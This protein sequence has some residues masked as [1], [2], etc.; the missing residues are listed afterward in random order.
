MIISGV[1][2]F[3]LLAVSPVQDQ[4]PGG[5]PP[6]GAGSRP[7]GQGQRQQNVDPKVAYE[8][9]TKDL[10]P[11]EGLFKVWQ[12][13]ENVY[14]EI[15]K[16]VIGRDLLWSI[17]LKASSNGGYSGSG[18]LDGMFRFEDR[19]DRVLLRKVVPN[20][21]A[22]DGKE[23]S[24]GLELANTQPIVRSF[25]LSGRSPD[26]N[27]LI[28]MGRI[29]KSDVPEL[30]ARSAFGGGALDPER[31]FFDKI[32]SYPEN[33]NVFVAVT[34][35]QG[36]AAGTANP[37]SRRQGGAGPSNSGVV[38]H[39]IVLLPEKPMMGRIADSR[40]GF[41]SNGWTEY[42]SQEQGTKEYAFIN[43]YR[44][45]KKDPSA[46]LSEPV[47]QIVYYIG[48]EV[49]AKW[50]PY[51][52]QGVE[53]WN[54]AFAE[55][56]FKNAI[57]AKDPPADDP[58]WDAGDAHTSCI[59][60]APLP[61]ANALGP[62]L[63][64]PR[65][66]EIMSAHVIIWHD[67]LKLQAEWYFSQVAPLD[68]RAQ[69]M[70]FP[71]DLMGDLIRFV[72]AHEVGHTLGLPHNGKASAMVPV[73]LLRDKKW[74]N[75]NGTCPSIMDYARFNYVAQPGDNCRLI[76]MVGIYDK[77]SIHWGYTPIAGAQDS[78]SERKTLDQWASAQVENPM[79]R[80]YDNFSPI[81][82]TAQSEALGDDAVT[83]SE[84]GVANLKRC[85]G[86]LLSG[87][88]EKGEDYAMLDQ[89]WASLRNQF[90]DYISHVSSMIGGV[91][92]TDY[93]AGRGGDVYA[94]VKP[95]D[96]RRAVKW[97]CDTVLETPK[98]IVPKDVTAKFSGDAGAV[99]VTSLQ[100]RAIGGLLNDA[101]IVRMR[102]TEAT[103]KGA[104]TVEQ[105]MGD[106][107]KCAFHELG[108]SRP[109]IDYYR[110]NMQ[111]TLVDRLTDKL[112]VRGEG[113][114]VA[115][116]ELQAI[117]SD[118]K[119]ALPK[120]SDKATNGHLQDLAEYISFALAN[121]DRVAP[122]AQAAPANPFQRVN[123]CPFEP[124]ELP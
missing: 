31:T 118:V 28:D 102:Q 101:R 112:S 2:L 19:G 37:F 45:E 79:L 100:S 84:Y 121:P 85:M 98:W 71:D 17:E 110:R 27:P 53:D 13:E 15:P 120:T 41:F 34:Y 70:P 106:L 42:G 94:A 89:F 64:D 81:D 9:T 50:R 123:W 29:F 122:P 115:R 6:G 62:S 55:A 26:G 18:I 3:S 46:A 40:V 99:A 1:L 56:G 8:Q 88:T 12:K 43:R 117:L 49:P 86:Y 119:A 72:V 52:K 22:K 35:G 30:S 114:S 4:P 103:D 77:F 54:A 92:Q 124:K 109:E 23:I 60:W 25:T 59:R 116:V 107:H 67:I 76:P 10:K 16:N 105:M 51:I 44:L 38:C 97:L 75:E 95:G 104:Y 32:A 20:A 108:D 36:A 24:Y 11:K 87:C 90:G 57:V 66:G 39:S 93:H 113:R 33:V 96:Q 21:R 68:P 73:R 74:T 14:F 65:S 47:K 63:T 48:P 5:G 69:K 111:R 58:N 78:W 83:A 61:I 82:P 7:G 80:F 91:I